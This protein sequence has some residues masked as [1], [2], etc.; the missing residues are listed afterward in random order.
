LF[1]LKSRVMESRPESSPELFERRARSKCFMKMGDS[2]TE[3]KRRI[4]KG[5]GK[6][7]D[8]LKKHGTAS[9]L[10]E[11]GARPLPMTVISRK[12]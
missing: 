10:R 4:R 11:R 6:K 3:E 8:V 12:T 2:I 5:R 1:H 7:K 9:A